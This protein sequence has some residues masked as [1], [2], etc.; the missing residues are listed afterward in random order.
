MG[1]NYQFDDFSLRLRFSPTA[2]SGLLKTA[3]DGSKKG[4]IRRYF[5]LHLTFYILKH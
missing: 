4:D 3:S 5:E 1:Q 2:P